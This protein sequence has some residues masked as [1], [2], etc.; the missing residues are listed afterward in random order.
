MPTRERLAKNEALFREVNARIRELSDRWELAAPDLIAFVCECS[1]AGCSDAVELTL[2]EYERIRT[3]PAQFLIVSGHLWNPELE[4]EVKRTDRFV[5]LEKRGP[6]EELAHE[7]DP[8]S[9]D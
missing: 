5:V 1:R 8:R 7:L 3:E 6:A 4:Q 2:D 9:G